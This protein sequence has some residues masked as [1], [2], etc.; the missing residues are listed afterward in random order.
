MAGR[1]VGGLAAVLLLLMVADSIKFC[2]ID[3]RELRPSN[4]G[5]ACQRSP[6]VDQEFSPE[7]L[8]FFGTRSPP[9]PQPS[10]ASAPH[11]PSVALTQAMNSSDAALWSQQE[12]SWPSLPS[13]SSRSSGRVMKEGLLIAGLV[14]GI[15][16]VTLLAA[17]A[18]IFLF[19]TSGKP[20]TPPSST[21]EAPPH[22]RELGHNNAVACIE[23][24]TA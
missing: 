12:E 2:P 8:T 20:S 5:L 6:P 14:C 17:S 7:M 10:S 18:V 4:H 16:G 3:A 22:P 19:Y 13:P 23:P 1:R 11:P 24:T 21:T 9:L 15:T